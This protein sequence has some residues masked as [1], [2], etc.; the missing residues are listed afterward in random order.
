M[1]FQEPWAQGERGPFWR[2]GAPKGGVGLPGSMTESSYRGDLLRMM[3]RV[4]DSAGYNVY[5]CEID[6]WHADEN[7]IYD[8]TGFRY[9]RLWQAGGTH[10]DVDIVTA[11]PGIVN[12]QGRLLY[13]HV[14]L[15]VRPPRSGNV[16]RHVL[17]WAG[18]ILLQLPPWNDTPPRQ[19][20]PRTIAQISGPYTEGLGTRTW[21]R[22][23]KTIVLEAGPF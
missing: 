1:A 3:F 11:L 8:D 2:H 19:A 10:A 7:G 20:D 5:G 13:R 12:Y 4:I 9:R 17:S 21:Y 22:L 23:S 14:H 16:T 6:I 18:E 15:D